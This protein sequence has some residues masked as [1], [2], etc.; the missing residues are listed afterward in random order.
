MSEIYLKALQSWWS[1][2]VHVPYLAIVS[3]ERPNL[4]SVGSTANISHCQFRSPYRANLRR[5]HL[6]IS[7][8]KIYAV[9]NMWACIPPFFAMLSVEVVANDRILFFKLLK[10]LVHAAFLS[11]CV[12]RG[13]LNRGGA[14]GSGSGAQRSSFGATPHEKAYNNQLAD[15]ILS[16]LL[17]PSPSDNSSLWYLLLLIT[18][19]T[20]INS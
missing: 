15:L 19:C 17:R 20:N 12:F 16:Q 18:P 9:S 2:N 1:W 10:W 4:E 11:A 14:P 7:R 3:Y 8:N 13:C 5:A 6:S